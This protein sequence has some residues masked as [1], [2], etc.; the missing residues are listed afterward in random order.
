M[1]CDFTIKPN[2][3]N[4]TRMSR[5]KLL[6]IYEYFENWAG[7]YRFAC[8]KGCASCCTQRVSLTTLEGELI[9][10]H[11]RSEQFEL[12]D[13]LTRLPANPFKQPTTNQF[14]A[15]CLQQEDNEEEIS[16]WDMTPC[17]FLQ[18]GCCSIYHVRPFMCR[19]F[20][21]KIL[22]HLSGEAEVD[23]R[24]LTLNTVILQCI[25]HLDQGR[26]WGSMNTILSLIVESGESTTK[27]PDR[28]YSLSRSIPGFLIPPEEI[29]AIQPR[30]Q[31]L[32]KI[33][34]SEV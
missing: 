19:S 14:A 25:E 30:L 32:L 7:D 6:K 8:R 24:F 9:A 23:P 10:D 34:N 20:G 22:C 13:I 31:V 15:S 1:G 18:D 29:D 21:S 12:L 17:T 2:R 28:E 16:P 26:P 4:N 33:I 27:H 3:D 11:I 5:Q